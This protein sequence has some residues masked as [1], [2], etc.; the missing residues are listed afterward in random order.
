M[1]SFL[2]RLRF[3]LKTA[4]LNEANFICLMRLTRLLG[5]GAARP[6][7]SATTPRHTPP[8]HGSAQRYITPHYTTPHHTTSLHTAPHH[9]TSLHTAPHHATPRYRH[10]MPYNTT[11]RHITRRHT[12]RHTISHHT[13]L[14]L[15]KTPL[16][17]YLVLTLPQTCRE[18]P[19]RLISHDQCC[20]N[21][22]EIR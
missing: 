4:K 3:G 12:P 7:H 9:T 17:H 8:R 16:Q 20:C 18:Y 11:P 22:M 15:H 10:T 19:P 21:A 6:R 1:A 5:L 2:L 13:T 14:R